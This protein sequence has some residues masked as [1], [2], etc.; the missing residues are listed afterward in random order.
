M[1]TIRA[2]VLNPSLSQLTATSGT[3]A[4]ALLQS[5]R[6]DGDVFSPTTGPGPVAGPDPSEMAAQIAEAS[7]SSMSASQLAGLADSPIGRQTLDGLGAALASGPQ[8]PERAEQLRRIDAARFTP[9]PGLQLHG[10]AADQ[11]SFV[12]LSRQTMIE[13]KGFD[14]SM[15]IASDDAQHPLDVNLTRDGKKARLDSFPGQAI[16]MQNIALLPASPGAPDPEGITQGA[17]L[18]HFIAEQRADA[19]TR[20]PGTKPSLDDFAEAHQQAIAAENAYR[21]EIGQKEDRGDSVNFEGPDGTSALLIH[22]DKHDSPLFFDQDGNLQPN[23]IPLPPAV[24][25]EEVLRG[26]GFEKQSND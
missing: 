17:V 23:S 5:L 20:Q 25:L 19:L 1:T 21:K 2:G 24:P 14:Q 3:T 6:L 7:A 13:S 9:G 8:T 4:K 10:D 22:Y 15:R 16:N 18:V 12:R 11:E 26:L